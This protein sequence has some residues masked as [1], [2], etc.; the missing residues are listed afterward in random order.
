MRVR[1]HVLSLARTRWLLVA[2]LAALI[3]PSGAHPV[4][5]RPLEPS[6]DTPQ[7]THARDA[8][9]KLPLAF[10]VNAGQ[11]DPSARFLA[12]GHGYTLALT[13]T[14]ALLSLTAPTAVVS[15]HDR[16][17][18]ASPSP[19][20][21][22]AVHFR[23]PGA[24]PAVAMRGEEALP[25]IVNYLV[26]NDPTR[27]HTHI[28]TTAK[29]RYTDLYPGVDLVVYGTE[30]DAWEYDVIVA[31]GADPAA[32][33][34][35]MEGATGV[36]LDATT[37]DLV[38]GTAVGAIRQ[39]APVL[40]QEVGGERQGVMGGYAMREDGTVGFAVGE[41]DR[42]LPL[43]IDP[44]LAYSTYLGGSGDDI[45]LGIAVDAGGNA[46]VTG[47][48]DGDAFVT[49]LDGSGA[50]L[51]S[52]RFGGGN[53]QGASIAVDTSGNAY[54]TGSTQSTN[55]PVTDGSTP[56]GLSDVFVAKLNGIGA[57]VYSTRFGGN[58]TDFGNG[59]AVDTS[60]NIYVTGETSSTNFP[61][62]DG[63]TYGGHRSDA[64]VAKLDGSGTRIY[65]THL[66]GSGDDN[67]AGI[68]VDTSGNA[69]V[70]GFTSSTNFPVTNGSTCGCRNGDA[71]AFVTKM[72]GSGVRVYS[73]FLGGSS[74]DRGR[75]IAVDTNGNAYVTGSTLSKN[76]PVTD[77][78]MLSG[79][80][81]FV[82]KLDR[83]GRLVY[84]TYLGG[85][86]DSNGYDI[87]VD[88][89]GNAYVT[90]FTDN[91]NFPVTDGSTPNGSLDV[92][93]A[94]LNGIGELIYS[95]R[96]GGSGE[97]RGYGIAVDASGNAY[98]TGDTS[99]TNFPVTDG[100]TFGGGTDASDAFVTK[101]VLVTLIT[102]SPAT[103]PNGI[104]G[105]L[106]GR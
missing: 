85:R 8:Y 14:E 106:A 41:Y 73:T 55:F 47:G 69:Y 11:G 46:Y 40:Y 96:F 60:G 57:L 19:P 31:P 81:A 76:F 95:T 52:T 43:V 100:S 65:S 92:F 35:S 23:F 51:Y 42:L 37:G 20:L 6:S 61:V 18:G 66:G 71:D 24:N 64:F 94:K 9:G 33:A 25:G 54:V 72:D 13:P 36:T 105:A 2:L 67:G 59:I 87:V 86:G 4:T 15:R 68:A 80:D 22:S 103:V 56:S 53:D 7:E 44:T 32:F 3:L 39:R 38:L 62:T 75:G 99:S 34:L 48:T 49:K 17:A 28:P 45:G 93:I 104:L 29:V 21:L 78:S 1:W 26:G 83:S 70:T 16:P 101:L 30:S 88:T 79:G 5:A 10:E 12:H 82:T 58:D 63:S 50:R 102:V 91:T 74:D 27:W 90:G 77:G 84:S 97:N 98:V 89:S